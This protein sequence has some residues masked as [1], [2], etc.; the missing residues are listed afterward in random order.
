M[1]AL[2]GL[3]LSVSLL[4]APHLFENTG[5]TTGLNSPLKMGQT[6]DSTFGAH[7]TT[8]VTVGWL[9]IHLAD[10]SSAYINIS[11]QGYYSTTLSSSPA[12]CEINGQG[13]YEG[14]AKRVNIDVHTS[15]RVVWTGSI[16]VIDQ[17]EIH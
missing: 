12:A 1:A 7:N 3:L 5:T 10:Q 2:F 14:V 16:I 9:T 13:F 17:D 6:I 8:S 4:S 15:V 11:G